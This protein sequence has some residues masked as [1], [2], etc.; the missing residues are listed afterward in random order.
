MRSMAML[1]LLAAAGPAGSG[2]AADGPAGAVGSSGRF[3]DVTA[4]C[5]VAEVVAAHYR[6]V[7]RWWL[8]G[9]TLVDLDGD[10]H[11]DLHLAGHGSPAAF[12]FNDG[13]GAFTYVDPKLSLKRGVR[14][15]ND[16]PYPGGEIRLPFDF[17]EDGRLDLLCSWHDGGGVMY[18]NDC[19]RDAAGPK[20][21][22]H[23]PRRL[24]VFCRGCAVFDVDRDGQVDFLSDAGKRIAVRFG[25]GRGTF[26]KRTGE[27]PG[28]FEQSG[29]IPADVDG[30]GH[31]DLLMHGRTGGNFYSRSPFE[32]RILRNDGKGRFVNVTAKSGLDPRGGSIHGVGDVNCDGHPDLICL[33]GKGVAVYLNDGRGRFVRRGGA[34]A[35]LD[36]VRNKPHALAWGG[37]VVTDLDNDALADVLVVARHLL[38]VLRGTGGGSFA[39]AN[40]DWRLPNAAWSAVDE[41][42]CFGDVNG[43]GMLDVITC[44]PGPEGKQKGVR[45]FRNDLPRRHWLRVRLIGGRGNR[46]AAGAKIRL[47]RPGTGAGGR[48]LIGYDQVCLWGRQSFHSYYAAAQTERHFGLGECEEVDV[49][50]EFCPSGRRVELRGVRADRTVTIREDNP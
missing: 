32:R 50:V 20:A 28:S 30:D 16:I 14:H 46:A 12:A 43:D 33:E 44:G 6:N 18:L 15:G 45:V 37:A 25:Q 23:R 5:G 35:G 40:D 2:A 34:V 31:V 41:G 22:F 13:S 26:G 8:S 29:F 42:L 17:D 1:L 48:E 9:M 39:Y 4:A 7:P 19:V 27:I 3:T 49:R 36:K 10:G 38:Y 47:Y 21:N 24:D 11:L